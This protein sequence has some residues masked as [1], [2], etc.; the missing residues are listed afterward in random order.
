MN[1]MGVSNSLTNDSVFTKPKPR[2]SYQDSKKLL[3]KLFLNLLFFE[4]LSFK[5]V[6]C[7]TE[8]P[9]VAS[10]FEKLYAKLQFEQFKK[11]DARLQPAYF[12]PSQIGKDA[13]LKDENVFSSKKNFFF[14]FSNFSKVQSFL[15]F[16]AK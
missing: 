12:A 15:F 9:L 10:V 1:K 5:N 14:T 8:V 6:N 7:C 4:M 3:F 2:W 16:F 11:Q 13:I